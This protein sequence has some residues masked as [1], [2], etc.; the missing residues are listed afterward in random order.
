MYLK[1]PHIVK[2]Q[3]P[4]Y[5]LKRLEDTR[6]SDYTTATVRI[7]T[8]VVNGG[9]LPLPGLTPHSRSP[10]SF[11]KAENFMSYGICTLDAGL[12]W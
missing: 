4:P 7:K 6:G 1:C 2:R 11:K 10:F 3:H 9:V 8:Q 12:T 5:V